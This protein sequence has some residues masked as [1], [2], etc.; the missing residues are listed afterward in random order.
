MGYCACRSP[1]TATTAA[2]RFLT[3][4]SSSNSESKVDGDRVKSSSQP[5]SKQQQLQ[6]KRTQ[7]L[8]RAKTNKDQDTGTGVDEGGYEVCPDMTP[9]QLAK[10]ANM[11][12]GVGGNELMTL[13]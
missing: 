13:L 5:C 12:D 10:A 9:S 2:E 4:S 6:K 11:E 7:T 1:E 8:R 3:S